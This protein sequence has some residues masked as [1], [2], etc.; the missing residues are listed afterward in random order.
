MSNYRTGGYAASYLDQPRNAY[1]SL[2]KNYGYSLRS[3]SY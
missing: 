3:K 2:S 1:N